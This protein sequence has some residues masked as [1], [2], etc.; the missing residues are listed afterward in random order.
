MI[1]GNS[2]NLTTLNTAVVTLAQS[3]VS[4]TSSDLTNATQIYDF[5]IINGIAAGSDCQVVLATNN[6]LYQS[7]QLVGLKVQLTKP[8]HCGLQ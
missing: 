2:T 1:A 3:G 7:K 4:A 8:L 6:G 5:A